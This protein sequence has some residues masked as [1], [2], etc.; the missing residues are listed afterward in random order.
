M[1]G[2]TKNPAEAR[3]SSWAEEVRADEADRALRQLPDLSLDGSKILEDLSRALVTLLLGPASAFATG[4]SEW[5]P[6]S[7]RLPILCAMFERQGAGCDAS[8]CV[9]QMEASDCKC[10]LPTAIAGRLQ[11]G[12]A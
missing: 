11:G 2:G 8:R 7:R 6:N 4:G 3:I 9:A 10:K 1:P 12:E 5:M